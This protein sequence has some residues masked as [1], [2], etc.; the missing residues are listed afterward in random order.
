[1]YIIQLKL[2]QM[3]CT[4][5]KTCEHLHYFVI[6]H[7][8]HFFLFW[9]ALKKTEKIGRPSNGNVEINGHNNVTRRDSKHHKYTKI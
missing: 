7:V 4:W 3:K 1:M 6:V 9:P 2:D 8:K 5:K